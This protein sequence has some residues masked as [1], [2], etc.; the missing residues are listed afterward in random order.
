MANQNVNWQRWVLLALL[1]IGFS[2]VAYCLSYTV[3]GTEESILNTLARVQA[4]IFAIV[5][6]VLI[7]GV[8]LS[9]SRYSPRLAS[10]FSS[11]P[12]Y[13]WTVGIFG[14]SIGLNIGLLYLLNL[15][16][17]FVQSILVVAA[18]LFAIGAFWT[19]YDFVNNTL[20]S[21]TPEGILERLDEVLTT[22][23]I[24][25]EAHDAD[26]SPTDP[27]PFLKL[28]SVI[29]STIKDNDVPSA[30]A[31]LSILGDKICDLTEEAPK[32]EF[33]EE[34]PLDNSLENVCVNQLPGLAED[35]V[36]EELIGPARGVVDTSETIGIA[37]IEEELDRILEHIVRG[38]SRL[39]VI[40]NYDRISEQVRNDAMDKS[41]DL[42]KA[43]ADQQI[44]T[45]AARGT[46]L[47]GSL[48]ALSISNR[49]SAGSNLGYTSLLILGF[50]KII[51]TAVES[52]V[53]LEEHLAQQWMRAHV[54]DE[55][56]GAS[57]LIASCYSSMTELTVESIVYEQRTEHSIV[58]WR[59]VGSGW[60]EG[61]E[62]LYNSGLESMA[63]LWL[64]TILYLEYVESESNSDVMDGFYVHGIS[65][66]DMEFAQS[67]VDKILDGDI[68]PRQLADLDTGSIDPLDAPLTGGRRPLVTDPE[69]EFTDWLRFRR[70]T[71]AI[72]RMASVEPENDE[73]QEE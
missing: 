20:Y 14:L 46:R 49:T 28:I 61:L 42:L 35:A 56:Q 39:L 9:A 34:S 37:A 15:F 18:F 53:D 4:A 48:A 57:L 12:A 36:D 50:P 66:I 1:L 25:V 13:K 6:S 64:A 32:E 59:S 67:T 21:T 45:G 10:S 7:L 72:G 33:E 54:V 71:L 26:G 19:M 3:P 29:R 30:S 23:S 41:K 65:K 44:W 62:S 27:D 51:S 16:S 40:L 68:N 60:S 63:E 8:R 31:G 47:L 38:L 5:F 17:E 55:I 22:R 24:T 58:R 2:I 52:D 73:D 70:Q 43:A 11:D 69:Q